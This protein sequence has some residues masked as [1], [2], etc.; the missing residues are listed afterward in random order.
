MA[1]TLLNASLVR[2]GTRTDILDK[3]PIWNKC[4]QATHWIDIRRPALGRLLVDLSVTTASQNMT[5]QECSALPLAGA[6]LR[7]RVGVC[8][9]LDL[10]YTLH[11]DAYCCTETRGNFTP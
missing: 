10:H 4:E 11:G 7:L 3:G 5:P 6:L 1:E 8:G 9:L 2:V